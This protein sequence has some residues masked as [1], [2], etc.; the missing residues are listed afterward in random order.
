MTDEDKARMLQK[1]RIA[2]RGRYSQMTD[3]EK[4][5]MLRR[6][7]EA[8]QMKLCVME[9]DEKARMIHVQE[10]Q[11][12]SREIKTE[13]EEVA[14]MVQKE[15]DAEQRLYLKVTDEKGMMV[16]NDSWQSG[17][18][19][20]E[21]EEKTRKLQSSRD[22]ERSIF[23]LMTYED[24]ELALENESE[25]ERRIND[26][27]QSRLSNSLHVTS[28][29]TC[30]E[31]EQTATIWGQSGEKSTFLCN[32]AVSCGLD[33][34]VF[35][36]SMHVVCDYCQAKKW[37]G[38]RC[39]MC[40]SNGKVQLQPIEGPCEVLTTLPSGT[41]HLLQHIEMYSCDLQMASLAVSAKVCEGNFMP[42][43]K[44]TTCLITFS[45]SR[46]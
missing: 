42:I 28:D 8:R 15:M 40:C 14:E 11:E 27:E 36:G 29:L 17:R 9:S 34:S 16:E 26:G 46:R 4:A 24:K 23:D 7:R 3:E 5:R 22:S 45:I 39:G 25:V 2:A 33:K 6:K 43:F 41:E 31:N 37:K 20:M 1:K 32:P 10:D 19:Q 44:V 12:R 35:I 38:E 18:N 13:E 30:E 21:S